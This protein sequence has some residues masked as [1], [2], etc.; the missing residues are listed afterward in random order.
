MAVIAPAWCSSGSH[1]CSGC[2]GEHL[3]T[4]SR[5][6]AGGIWRLSGGEDWGVPMAVVFGGL[7]RQHGGSCPYVRPGEA[8]RHGEAGTAIPAGPFGNGGR[9]G[10]VVA[11]ALWNA[12]FLSQPLCTRGAGRSTSGG[13]RSAHPL[14]RRYAGNFRSIGSVVRVHY[15]DRLQGGEQL[16]LRAWPRGAA[17]S[18]Y[19]CCG[20]RNRPGSCAVVV[21]QAA[22]EA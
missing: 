1:G 9:A 19:S 15:H 3:S 22:E 18:W 21:H 13:R 11:P 6:Y 12:R 10:S 14:F 17:G 20:R 8:L 7:G 16:G 5:R 2:G 4:D